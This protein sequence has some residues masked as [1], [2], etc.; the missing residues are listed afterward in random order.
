MKQNNKTINKYT[1]F[2][3]TVI[4]VA[5]VGILFKGHIISPAEAFN[6]FDRRYLEG[7]NNNIVMVSQNQ[8]RIMNLIRERCK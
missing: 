6:Q 8:G 5:M 1:N 3:L 2:I 7:I 4:A